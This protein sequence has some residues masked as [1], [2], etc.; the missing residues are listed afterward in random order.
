VG[1]PQKGVEKAVFDGQD[2]FEAMATLL[3]QQCGEHPS[4]SGPAVVQRLDLVQ[5]LEVVAGQ[6]TR[7]RGGQTQGILHL[8]SIQA[9]Q[10]AG[11]D[12]CSHGATDAGGELTP[13]AVVSQ[14]ALQA[15]RHL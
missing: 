15:G 5:R 10:Q 12:R 11:A 9:K 14:D 13:G 1:Q 4:L 3:S 7:P 6:A 8:P 2:L